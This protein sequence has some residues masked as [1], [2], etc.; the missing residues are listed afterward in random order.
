M[1]FNEVLHSFAADDLLKA[2]LVLIVLD[3]ALGVVAAIVNKEQRFKFNRLANFAMDD[4]VGKVFPW[5][6][7]YSTAKFAPSVDVLGVNLND[8]QKAVWV[9]VAASLVASLLESLS[10]LGFQPLQKAV[11][12]VPGLSSDGSEAGTTK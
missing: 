3:F 1:T 7:V 8:V 10:Q 12:A 2:V 11:D 9:V 6:I 5:F 4:V